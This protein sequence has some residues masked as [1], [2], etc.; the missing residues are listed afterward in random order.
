V[1]SRSRHPKK[2][3][4]EAVQRAEARGW[5]VKLGSGHCWATLRCPRTERSGCQFI[6]FSTPRNPGNHAK[7]ILQA[8]DDCDHVATDD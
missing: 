2:E 8:L 6:V 4:E 7:R 3:V 1:P 5:R